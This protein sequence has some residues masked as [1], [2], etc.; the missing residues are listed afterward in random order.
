MHK[1]LIAAVF[2]VAGLGAVAAGQTAA[3]TVKVTICHVP[4]GNPGN[5]HTITVGSEAVSAHMAHGDSVGVCPTFQP[6]PSGGGGDGGP[7]IPGIGG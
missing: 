2:A 7:G 3:G 6:P 4:P 1:K 5:A